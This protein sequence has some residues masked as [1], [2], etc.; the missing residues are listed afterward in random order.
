[1]A[2]R[3]LLS[4]QNFL[5]LSVIGSIFFSFISLGF[6]NVLTANLENSLHHSTITPTHSCCISEIIVQVS[7]VVEQFSVG[8]HPSTSMLLFVCAVTIVWVGLSSVH[9]NIALIHSKAYILYQRNHPE[10]TLFNDLTLSYAKGILN[11]KTH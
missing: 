5:A 11:P 2:N 1:M 3:R 10:I 8:I 9:E 4:F 7:E 6:L